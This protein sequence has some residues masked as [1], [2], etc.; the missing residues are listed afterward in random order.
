MNARQYLGMVW[1]PA[2]MPVQKPSVD[3]MMAVQTNR[4]WLRRYGATYD[5]RAWGLLAITSILFGI[6]PYAIVLLIVAGHI[7]I[8]VW[9][10]LKAVREDSNNSDDSN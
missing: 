10:M 3:E 7:R 4:E 1:P 9:R 6:W 2:L 5:R 8:Q